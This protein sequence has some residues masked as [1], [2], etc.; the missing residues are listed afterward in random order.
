MF[1]SAGPGYSG[2]DSVTSFSNRG[3]NHAAQYFTDASYSGPSFIQDKGSG[4]SHLGQAP[5]ASFNDVL[6]SA[7]FVNEDKF[8]V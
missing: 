6:S 5:G 1:G 8:G 7:K 4:D 3:Q 2:N